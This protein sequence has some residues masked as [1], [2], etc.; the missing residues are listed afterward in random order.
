MTPYN[1]V[2]W[3]E[4]LFLRP[5]HL[6]QQERYLERYMELHAGALRPHAWGF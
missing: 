5:Q 4:G 6:Q 3:S 2:I 1:K